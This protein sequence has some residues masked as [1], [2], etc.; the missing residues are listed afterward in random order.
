MIV[1]DIIEFTVDVHDRG[2]PNQERIVLY[3]NDTVNL[4]QYGLMIGI[5]STGNSAVPIRDNFLWFGDAII[6]KGDWIFIYTGPGEAKSTELPNSTNRLYS[7][8]WGRQKTIL[9]HDDLV[10][11][12]FRVDAVQIPD[13]NN[14]L[15]V[16]KR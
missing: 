3:A 10:P 6:N 15:L 7:I 11:I 13:K 8:H 12:F 9:H 16:K 14:N 4:G 2:V 1:G 5:R